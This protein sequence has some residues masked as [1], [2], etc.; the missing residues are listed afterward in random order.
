MKKL[1]SVPLYML[2]L[3][4]ALV[5]LYPVF[6]VVML[7]FRDS[8]ELRETIGPIIG[9]TSDTVKISYLAQFPTLS[10]FSKLL[11][12]TPEFYM[13]FW[14][15]FA[16]VGSI[17]AL[18]VL[19]AVPAAWAFTRFRFKGRKLLFNLYVI[20]MLMPFQVT[21]LSQYLVL[22]NIHLM[23]TRLAVI[24]PAVFSAFPVFLIYRGFSDIPGDIID[25]AR[26][27]GAGEWKVLWHIGLPLGKQ[28]I[29]AC[30]VLCFLDY[31]NMVEQP[32]AFIK[33]KTKWPLSLYLPSIDISQAE[34]I[35]AASVITLIPAVFIFIIGQ[36]YL[37]QGI[38]ASALKE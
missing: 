36:D 34:M 32:L 28:G 35:L 18:Q 31:W 38:I 8:F 6:L 21:M 19:I 16:L 22:N 30:V 1:K 33:D 2:F 15:S 12:Y 29:L 24:L 23:N 7:S 3:I 14:N 25:A 5:I 13:V 10:H 20:L 4:L 9:S 27:D 37:E 26:I 17:L 11:I